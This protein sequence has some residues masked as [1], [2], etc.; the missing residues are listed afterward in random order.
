MSKND[1]ANVLAILDAI[2]QIQKY[3]ENIDHAAAFHQNRIVFD[4]TLMNFVLIGEMTERL[5][6]EV[7][8]EAMHVEWQKIKGFRNMIAHDYLGIDAEEVWQIIA[9]DLY[10]LRNDIREI[11]TKLRRA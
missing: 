4:A 2:D 5:S 8:K 3:T 10:P 1:V 6:D 11:L 7:K 9:D